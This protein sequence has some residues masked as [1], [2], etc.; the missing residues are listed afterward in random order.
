[1]MLVLLLTGGLGLL[2]GLALWARHSIRCTAES[3]RRDEIAPNVDALMRFGP[4]I[5]LSPYI[6]A[7]AVTGNLGFF[8]VP[9]VVGWS[10][11]FGWG[12]A[13]AATYFV[14][15]MLTRQAIFAF[16]AGTLARAQR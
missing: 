16:I 14:S 10:C 3:L 15:A 9:I 5:L 6:M 8:V 12:L 4:R 1:M 13:A 7:L 2:G 11:G